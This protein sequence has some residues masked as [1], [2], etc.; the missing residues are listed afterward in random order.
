MSFDL[1]FD[2]YDTVFDDPYIVRVIEPFDVFND[3]YGE[4]GDAEERLRIEAGT[5]WEIYDPSYRSDVHLYGTGELYEWELDL[6]W[7]CLDTSFELI[8]EGGYDY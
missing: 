7:D 2:E 1:R 3:L 4:V 8:H 6:P 5:E